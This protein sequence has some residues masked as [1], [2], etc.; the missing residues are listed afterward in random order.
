MAVRDLAEE[1][2]E[3]E[4][5]AEEAAVALYGHQEIHFRMYRLAWITESSRYEGLRNVVLCRTG[6]MMRRG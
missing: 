2:E 6:F 4:E 5:E 3:K 1:K